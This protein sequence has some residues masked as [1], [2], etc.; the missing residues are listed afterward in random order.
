MKEFLHYF[1]S[2]GSEVEFE[3][4]TLPHLLLILVVAAVFLLFFLSYLPWLIKDRKVKKAA[5]ATAAQQ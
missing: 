1:F 5:Q 3:N 2:A 4:F